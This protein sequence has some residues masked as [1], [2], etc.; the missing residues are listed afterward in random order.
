MFFDI[1]Q[2]RCAEMG[3]KVTP[4]L[5]ELGLSRSA[6]ARWK[7]GT[8]PNGEVLLKLAARLDCSVDY[9]LGLTEKPEVNR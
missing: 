3:I 4:L 8:L 2:S 5:D 7:S 1:L 6:I 9:L